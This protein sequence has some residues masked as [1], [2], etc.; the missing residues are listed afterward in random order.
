[1]T[2][3]KSFDYVEYKRSIQQRHAAE[4]RNMNSRQKSASRL[5]WLKESDN[6]A[7]RLWREMSAK[8]AE[9]AAR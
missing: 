7:A 3:P 1:M 8:Q 4:T 5:Q 6:P 2:Q 9:A